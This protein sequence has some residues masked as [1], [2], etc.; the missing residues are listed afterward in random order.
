MIQT[1]KCNAD[2]QYINKKN[3]DVKNKIPDISGLVTIAVLNTKTGEAE[4]KNPDVS[5]LTTKAVLDTKIS[6]VEN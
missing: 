6:K 4:N 2:T 3:R 1:S 5:D